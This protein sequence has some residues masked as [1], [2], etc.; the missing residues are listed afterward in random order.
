MTKGFIFVVLILSG[1]SC[2]KSSGPKASNYTAPAGTQ[3]VTGKLWYSD[4]ASDG[5]GLFF[6]VDTGGNLLFKNEY[7]DTYQQYLHFKDL[8]NL[9][10]RLT[11]TATGDSSCLFSDIPGYCETH[12]VPIVEVKSL[13]PQ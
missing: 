1:F 4:P 3:I 5:S 7:A 6:A 12:Q 9:H 2:M 10:C 8:V 11:F 13:Q